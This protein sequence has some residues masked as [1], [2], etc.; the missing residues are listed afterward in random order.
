M[1]VVNTGDPG[2]LQYVKEAYAS[3]L[4]PVGK[5]LQ[6]DAGKFVTPA[7]LEVI[8]SNQN[9]NYSR[10]LLFNYAI[11]FYH[12]G[13][14]AKYT[15]NDKYSLTGYVV[16]GYNN[17]T[18]GFVSGLHTGGLNFAWNLTKKVSITETWMGGPGP[19]PQ[20]G[21]HWRNLI[22]S[23]ITYS[24]TAKL[25]LAL[26]GDYA[27]DQGTILSNL[28]A[29]WYGA[30][31][32]VK[33]QLTPQY[34]VAARYEYYDDP[35]GFSIGGSNDGLFAPA[36]K[37]HIQAGTLTVERQITQHV[38]ARAEFRHDLSSAPFFQKSA[39]NDLVTGQST[40]AGGLIFVLA[41]AK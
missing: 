23:V 16:D 24:A 40:L 10:D 18:S 25:S 35:N 41:P 17:V 11:P 2:A 5:G 32:Y 27:R 12:F 15:F 1:K 38:I 6:V 34:A 13:L 8:E 30:A 36:P 29:D 3:Y 9:W 20:D 31:G 4:V 14:R 33:Y 26:W 7:G 21:G 22:D 28:P 19:T 37:Q 39:A